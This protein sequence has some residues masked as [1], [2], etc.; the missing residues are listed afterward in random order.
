MFALALALALFIA[1]DTETTAPADPPPAEASAEAPPAEPAAEAAP[2]PELP[3]PVGAPRD[4]YGLVAWCYGA[5]RGYLD[6]HDQVMPEV[7][8]IESTYRRPGSDLEADLKDYADMQKAGRAD[9]KVLARAMEAAEKAS[10]K[11]INAAGADAVRRGRGVWIAGP[12]TPKARVAQEWMSWSPAPRCL[13]TAVALESRAKLM[14]SAFQVNE[15]VAAPEPPPAEVA[16][17]PTAP[18]TP[19]VETPAPEAPTPEVPAMP[20]LRG[21]Q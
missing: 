12:D 16:E 18:E 17:A 6:L 11:P 2:A 20:A 13:P 5:L 1:Q 3:F 7:I 15:P 14:G 19:P 8:R 21:P 4:D 9:L 10:M